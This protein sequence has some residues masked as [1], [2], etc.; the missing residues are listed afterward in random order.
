MK[1]NLISLTGRVRA[2][3]LNLMEDLRYPIGPFH[4]AGTSTPVDRTRFIAEIE[5]LPVELRAAIDGLSPQQLDTP[6]RPGGW[7]PRQVVHHLPDSHLNSYIRFKLALTEDEPTIR[8][9]DEGRWAELEDGRT[10]PVDVSLDLLAALHKRWVLVLRAIRDQDWS[11]RLHHPASGVLSLDAMLANYAWHGR[12]HVAQITS[13]RERMGW[14]E[15]P[16]NA[17]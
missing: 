3:I 10:G 2:D 11:R 13:L 14:T 12:H 7:T 5:R 6:Y 15:R 9:Y 16:G 4:Y 8:P 1:F 17:S